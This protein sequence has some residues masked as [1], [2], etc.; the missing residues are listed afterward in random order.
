MNLATDEALDFFKLKNFSAEGIRPDPCLGGSVWELVPTRADIGEKFDRHLVKRGSF[1]DPLTAIGLPVG[2]SSIWSIM[3]DYGKIANLLASVRAEPP[4]GDLLL[5]LYDPTK[6]V[7]R[8]RKIDIVLGEKYVSAKRMAKKFHSSFRLRDTDESEEKGCWIEIQRCLMKDYVAEQDKKAFEVLKTNSEAHDVP[9][10]A[11]NKLPPV[12]DILD[13]LFELK[14]KVDLGY[15]A[16]GI[17]LINTDIEELLCRHYGDEKGEI[18]H[19]CNSPVVVSDCMD[20][21]TTPSDGDVCAMY[22]DFESAG[23]VC[24]RPYLNLTKMNAMGQECFYTAGDFVVEI[25]VPGAYAR[26]RVGE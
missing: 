1:L 16:N 25:R 8:D 12:I 11:S 19:V 21:T 6:T 22:G 20:D 3:I 26:L 14:R 17:F 18:T 2:M 24:E 5:P 4:Y 13:K 10:G 23:V 7:E 15:R 9:T